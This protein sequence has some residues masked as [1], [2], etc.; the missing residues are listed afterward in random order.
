MSLS[1]WEDLCPHTICWEPVLSRDGYGKP[2][3]GAASTFRGRRVFKIERVPSGGQGEGA[4]VLSSSQ[5]WILGTPEVGYEDRV[6]VQGDIKFPPILNVQKF[7]DESGD[8]FV[9]VLLG[10]AK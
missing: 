2:T 7:P 3:Y 8:F 9:K 5:I 1:D 4:V 6:Y 10:S